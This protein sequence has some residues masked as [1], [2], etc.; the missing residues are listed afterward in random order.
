M[1]GAGA[2]DLPTTQ[3]PSHTRAGASGDAG[4]AAIR[5]AGAA[6]R[7][8]VR[9]A[10]RVPTPAAQTS[11]AT[12]NGLLANP[13]RVAAAVNTLASVT[14]PSPAA[15]PAANRVAIAARTCSRSL[16]VGSS[17]MR[18][19]SRSAFA[20]GP[21]PVIGSSIDRSLAIG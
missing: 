5:A 4:G 17:P 8:D 3:D 14:T 19:A 1:A 11:A 7:G 16:S 12:S 9:D 21:S 13:A 6:E 2:G 18:A 10:T 15:A 20:S